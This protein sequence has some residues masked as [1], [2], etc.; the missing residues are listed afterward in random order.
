MSEFDFDKTELTAEVER[1]MGEL[2]DFCKAHDLPMICE[3]CTL[4]YDDGN[5]T[6]TQRTKTMQ[7]AIGSMTPSM[8]CYVSLSEYDNDVQHQALP[9]ILRM[10]SHI[11]ERLTE[12]GN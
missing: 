6:E 11:T 9:L 1:R 4:H 2:F 10:L 5:V 7:G 8:Q 12:L 3:V